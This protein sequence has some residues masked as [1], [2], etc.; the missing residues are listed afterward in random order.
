MV[1][2]Y[3]IYLFP[4]LFDKI[5]IKKIKNKIKIKTQKN[6]NISMSKIIENYLLT[7]TVGQGQYGKVYKAT[8]KKI[9][10]SLYAIKTIKLDKFKTVP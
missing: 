1:F 5:L 7:E 3:N 10:N 8:H 2:F 4:T 6:S 9:E